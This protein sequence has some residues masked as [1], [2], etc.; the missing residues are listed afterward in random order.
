MVSDG[1]PLVD[2]D[3]RWRRG[4][5]AAGFA[6][7]RDR[8][9]FTPTELRDWGAR[10]EAI[11]RREHAAD[12]GFTVLPLDESALRAW[13]SLILTGRLAD[14]TLTEP[15]RLPALLRRGGAAR[16]L[17]DEPP[18][19]ATIEKLIV[20]LRLYLGEQGLRW[21]AALA[22]LPVLRWELTLLLGRALLTPPGRG[23]AR[24]E[25]ELLARHYRRLVRL[26]WLQRSVLP[27][28]LRL[29]LLL[30]LP[31]GE[32][33]RVQEQA[34]MLLGR[35]G[36]RAGRSGVPLGFDRVEEGI[37]S[38]AAPPADAIYVG[39]MSGLDA[40]QLLLRAPEHWRRWLDRIELPQPRNWRERL[41]RWLARARGAWARQAWRD[42]LP[43]LGPRAARLW[44]AP[45]LLLPLVA[46]LGWAAT[47]RVPATSVA[48]PGFEWQPRA[49]AWPAAR[50]GAPAV[51]L[52]GLERALVDVGGGRL[53]Q[54]DLRS[55]EAVGGDWTGA[56]KILQV[57]AVSPDGTRVAAGGADGAV[58]VFDTA[59][60]QA[61]DLQAGAGEPVTTLSFGSDSGW[62]L[63]TAGRRL[64]LWQRRALPVPSASSTFE[65][66]G[67]TELRASVVAAISQAGS[68]RELP[69]VGADGRMRYVGAGP[70]LSVREGRELPGFGPGPVA[71]HSDGVQV[72]Q[73]AAEGGLRVWSGSRDDPEQ[74][75]ER[76]IGLD[77]EAPVRSL[78]YTQDGQRLIVI[79][80]EGR[81]RVWDTRMLE[82]VG[83]ATPLPASASRVSIAADGRTLLVSGDD[84]QVR[85]L[86]A[87]VAAP[88]AAPLEVAGEIMDIA[89]APDGTLAALGEDGQITWFES[90]ASTG[91]V[92]ADLVPR[93]CCLVFADRGKRLIVGSLDGSLMVWTSSTSQLRRLD[94]HSVS[95]TALAASGDGRVLASA[96]VDGS[97]QWR[98]GSGAPVGS[99]HDIDG[100]VEAL[101]IDER[102]KRLLIGQVDGPVIEWPAGRE[103]RERRLATG[104]VSA[105]SL[106]ANGRWAAVGST[107][108]SIMLWPTESDA[109]AVRSL[110]GLD[111]WVAA[112]WFD[113]PAS[114]CLQSE[115]MAR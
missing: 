91:R 18:D 94:G 32:Q 51:L 100:I 42:G 88:L 34:R 108:G 85:L 35:I 112:L 41:H 99:P 72:V 15:Q 62:L 55:G 79:D 38:A 44:L 110:D 4:A 17:G 97:L 103:P 105:V 70:S 106:S 90:G 30:E 31:D 22:V 109:A 33:Q 1:A 56:P 24:A 102:G 92:L 20:Q 47:Q 93:P 86:H 113:Q 96:G 87:G 39:L 52:P 82:P 2:E 5:R 23:G 63:S 77:S 14:I 46:L 40:E 114:G 16:L 98:D 76:R 26:P 50:A 67:A 73:A 65:L 61:T 19:R 104:P 95:V 6:R 8:A 49:L 84:A 53:R 78:A 11:E 75:A 9:L 74:I 71:V 115:P 13:T 80:T 43:H 21:L 66:G 29:R 68:M 81:L 59:D 60:G 111:A 101:A 54:F 27:D 83:A 58:V 7:W 12:P 48:P 89:I 37:G 45:W 57:L 28:W 25:A 69:I 107:G 3:G 10:E 64:T 36:P